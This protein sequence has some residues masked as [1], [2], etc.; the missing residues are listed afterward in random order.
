MYSTRRNPD[1]D[2][3]VADMPRCRV[4]SAA[5]IAAEAGSALVFN[6]VIDCPSNMKRGW[7]CGEDI[8]SLSFCKSGIASL[9]NTSDVA[10]QSEPHRID[11]MRHL[12][13][14]V[15]LQ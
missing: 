12:Y 1:I 6:L 13:A 2:V 4:R 3:D 9:A 7:G 15:S 8:R 5:K 14:L 10:N 11:R